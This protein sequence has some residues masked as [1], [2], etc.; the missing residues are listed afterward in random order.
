[1]ARYRYIIS[2]KYTA[3]HIFVE[4][5]TMN[6]FIDRPNVAGCNFFRLGAY[7][8]DQQAA[9]GKVLTFR[10][11]HVIRSY[12]VIYTGNNILSNV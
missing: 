1:M 10:G 12:C 11:T 8:G 4:K 5:K 2:S 7:W 9:G 6:R 3:R